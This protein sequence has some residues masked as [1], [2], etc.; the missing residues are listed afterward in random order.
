[1]RC[2]N[3]V[4]GDI[5]WFGSIGLN[6]DGTAIFAN[7]EH[8][9]YANDRD[10][11]VA[12]LTERLSVIKNE[13]W[14]D[15]RYGIPLIDK[16]SSKAEMDVFIIQIVSEHP[17]VVSVTNFESKMIQHNYTCNMTINTI[18]GDISLSI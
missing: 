14:Y 15:M 2:R 4:N 8:E 17:D 18:Y 10:G 7:E 12:S 13:L 11:T 5:V 6:D 3:I 9:S 1:M 16:V